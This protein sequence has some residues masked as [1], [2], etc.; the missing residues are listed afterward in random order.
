MPSPPSSSLEADRKASSPSPSLALA[1]ALS[2]LLQTLQ[3]SLAAARAAQPWPVDAARDLLPYCGVPAGTVTANATN[4]MANI[5]SGDTSGIHNA[6]GM[7]NTGRGNGTGTRN[8]TAPLL[9]ANHC[10]EALSRR[11]WFSFEQL[12]QAMGTAGGRRAVADVVGQGMVAFWE[13]ELATG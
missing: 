4:D 13:F 10:A 11:G 3:S 8:Y 7:Y 9:S 1:Q 2:A 5:A 12:V 6:R